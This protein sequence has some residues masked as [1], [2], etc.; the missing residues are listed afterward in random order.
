VRGFEGLKAAHRQEIEV[1]E[2]QLQ[3]LKT[4][5]QEE[6]GGG[7]SSFEGAAAR[8]EGSP[9][10]EDLQRQITEASRA[11]EAKAGLVKTLKSEKEALE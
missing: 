6:V 3:D 7:N 8:G 4:K 9:V 11:L 5:Y 2:R 10:I 1:K